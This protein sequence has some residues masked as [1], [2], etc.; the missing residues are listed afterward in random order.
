MT[1]ANSSTQASSR[2]RQPRLPDIRQASP[3]QAWRTAVTTGDVLAA[4]QPAAPAAA[5]ALAPD[6]V[7]TEKHSTIR[8]VIA[9]SMQASLATMAQLT[10]NSSFD[11]SD[12][13]GLRS[14]LKKAAEQGLTAEQGFALAGQVPTIN[15]IILYAVSRVLARHP[16]CNAHYDD[17]KMTYFRHVHLGVA[18]IPRAA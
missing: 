8:K 7:T 12:M 15:D 6:D 18:S 1:S 14:R 4:V 5:A 16:A 17:E 9:R 10:L 11:A 13:L 2:P 3:A